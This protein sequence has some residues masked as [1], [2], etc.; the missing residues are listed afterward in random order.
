MGNLH[1]NHKDLSLMQP[2]CIGYYTHDLPPGR[3]LAGKEEPVVIRLARFQH[4]LRELACRSPHERTEACYETGTGSKRN[5]AVAEDAATASGYA[6]Y[7]P[8]PPLDLD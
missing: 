6:R 2:T 3:V 7:R 1:E 5:F 4:A 8:L